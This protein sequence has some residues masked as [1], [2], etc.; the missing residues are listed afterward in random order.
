MRSAE[1]RGQGISR[2]RPV[3]FQTSS[4]RG[5]F[6]ESVTKR[7]GWEPVLNGEPHF[8][9]FGTRNSSACYARC[10]G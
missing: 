10:P 7:F 6:S 2:A 1:T 5:R 9:A 3:R 4:M 8:S